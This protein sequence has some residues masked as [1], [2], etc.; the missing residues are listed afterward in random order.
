MMLLIRVS[1]T[2]R[3]HVDHTFKFRERKIC[4]GNDV[5]PIG[6]AK[7][8]LD[9]FVFGQDQFKFYITSLI[10]LSCGSY[11]QH[12]GRMRERALREIEGDFRVTAGFD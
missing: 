1:I 3:W 9:F 2:Q 8:P 5:S 7:Q 11:G 10:E 6:I 12:R 4:W